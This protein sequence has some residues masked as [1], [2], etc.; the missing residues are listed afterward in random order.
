MST[1]QDIYAAGSENRPPMLNKEHYVPW[2][3]RLLRYAKSRPNGKLIYNSI[4]NGPYVS[5]MIPELGDAARTVSVLETI[6]EQT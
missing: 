2:S 4:I 1:Q 6:H 3:A 5:R